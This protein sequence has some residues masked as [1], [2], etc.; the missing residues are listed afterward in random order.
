[1]RFHNMFLSSS[2]VIVTLF[3]FLVTDDTILSFCH[4]LLGAF[5]LS[6]FVGYFE[7]V[8][9]SLSTQRPTCWYS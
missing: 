3:G 6:S 1:M 2:L 9:V 7:N 5:P 8:Q 4:Q